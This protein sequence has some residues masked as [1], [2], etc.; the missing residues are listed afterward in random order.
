MIDLYTS[1]TPNGWK[2]SIALEELGLGYQ[3]HPISLSKGEQKQ[4]WY[5]ELNPNGRIP[6]IVDRDEGGYVVFESGAILQYL[7][8]K[9]GRLMPAD[10]KGRFE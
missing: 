5:L 8:E 4:D 7:A 10:R 1:T 6:T 9:T 2:A 3:T